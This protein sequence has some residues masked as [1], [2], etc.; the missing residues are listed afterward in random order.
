VLVGE[1]GQEQKVL[2]AAITLELG[3]HAEW[4]EVGD[5]VK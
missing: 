2:A 3:Q 1:V 4:N 5:V